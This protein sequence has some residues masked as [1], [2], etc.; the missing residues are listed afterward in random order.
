MKR[1]AAVVK[2]TIL[3]VAL[4][5][6]VLGG[7]AVYF[8]TLP[9]ASASA[10]GSQ[11]ASSQVVTN[12]VSSGSYITVEYNGTR[13]QVPPKGANSPD[14]A[15]PQGT[16]PSL[17]TLLQETCG[18]GIGSAQEPWKTCYN[19]VF[20]AGCSGDNSCDP[21]THECSSPASACM[22]IAGGYSQ[23]G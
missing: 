2:V 10:G 8:Y 22:V 16:D 6:I 15:C 21:F 3:A 4:S 7:L 14:F 19:C 11:A 18:N 12:Q 5:S 23:A 13:Y 20:D 17:C 9:P 1:S